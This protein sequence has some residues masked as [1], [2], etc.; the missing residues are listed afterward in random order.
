[1][2]DHIYIN[3]IKNITIF[4]QSYLQ[5]IKLTTKITITFNYIYRFFKKGNLK[6]EIYT[7]IMWYILSLIVSLMYQ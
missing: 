3:I 5:E 7:L 2:L 6:S 4:K 1:M